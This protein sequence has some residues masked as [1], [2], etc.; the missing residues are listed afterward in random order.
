MRFRFSPVLLLLAIPAGTIRAQS[1]DS[2]SRGADPTARPYIT[3]KLAS[4]P[5]ELDGHMNEAAWATADSITDFKQREPREGSPSTERTLMKILRDKDAIY[6]AA[7]MDD[8]DATAIVAMQLR[9]DVNLDSDDQ[10]GFLIDSFHDHRSAFAFNTNPNGAMW[11]AQ[12]FEPE[13]TNENWNGIWDVAVTRDANGWTAEFRIPFR[14]LRFDAGAGAAFGF[15]ARR[16]IRR[17]N[18]EDLWQGWKRNEGI[19][20]LLKEGD[21]V[22]LGVLSRARNLEL[23]PYT[24]ARADAP[25]YDVAGA[26]KS[27]AST[28]GKVGLDAKTA[29]TPTLTADLTV[30]T[31]F[32]QV[33]A[34]RQIVNLSRF[35]LFFPEKREFFLESANIFSFGSSGRAQPFHSR[36]IGLDYSGRPVPILGG[37][38][39]S[40][41]AG[42][43]AVGLLDARTGAGDAANDAVVRVKHNVFARSYVGGI[44]INRSGPDVDGSQSLAGF[45][46]DFPL[47][48]HGRN[49]EPSFWINGSRTPGHRGTPL[50]WRLATD[51]P[52]DL[53]DNFVSLYRINAGY[54][55]FLGFVRRTGIW[56][57]NGHIDYF[58]RP[59]IGGVRKL[60]IVAP[61]PS[62]DIIADEAGSLTSPKTWQTAEFEWTPLGV[63]MQSGDY[64]EL[65]VQRKMD[66][67]SSAFEIFPDI[68]VA[69][70]RYWWTRYEAEYRSSIGRPLSVQPKVSVGQFYD[71][72]GA[73]LSTSVTFRGGGHVILG[74][75]YDYV[76]ARVAGGHFDAISTGGRIEYAFTTR[77]D[78]LGFVQYNNEDRRSD[79]NLRFHWTPVIGDDL[80]VVWNSGYSTDPLA[81]FR[82]GSASTIVKPLN[83]AL[84]IKGVHRLAY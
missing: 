82:F 20:Y 68:N 10:F 62:W 12:R 72:H 9:R 32:A 31:D 78:F 37:A 75:D 67:P 84:V 65:N 19:Y 24:L 39:L 81:R 33:E 73:E 57:S 50:A 49:V 56:E 1:S 25:S 66:A 36:R 8:R 11:D 26:R 42:P 60:T 38:R 55:P 17:K 23:K 3:V 5:I 69:S 4:T 51:Y 21:L 59:K 34:D 30:N 54:D 76:S 45:D 15:N 61:V 13:D 79:F 63:T 70:G 29:V 77:A 80:Y 74:A 48:V 35:P 16:F 6:V 28:S 18:E 83:G 64:Y 71:G 7:R 43:W 52:N 46:M 22:G 14:T 47:V 2:L 53:F 41:K 27:S 40:G 58:P 44:L